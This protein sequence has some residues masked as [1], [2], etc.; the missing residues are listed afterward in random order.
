MLIS[1][2]LKTIAKY[3]DKKAVVADIGTDHG[4]IIAYLIENDIVTRAFAC[5]LNKGPLETARRALKKY[6]AKAEITFKLSNG[7]EKLTIEDGVDTIVIAGMGG[8][9]IEKIIANDISIAKNA[10]RMILSPNIAAEDLRSFLTNNSWEIIM[11]D[12]VLEDD[13][14]YPIIVVEK[15]KSISLSD[16]LLFLGPKIVENMHPLMKEFIDF[17]ERKMLCVIEAMESSN[18]EEAMQKAKN[19]KLKL[20]RIKK[21]SKCQ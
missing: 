20:E 16:E 15:G 8:K 18:N 19:L 7:L 10:K 5:D 17:E 14:F 3:V 21:V 2:R 13:K 6:E 12:L 9:L 1:N 11:E 4:L